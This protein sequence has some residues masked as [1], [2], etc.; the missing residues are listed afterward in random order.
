MR[1]LNA[2]ERSLDSGGSGGCRHRDGGGAF[3][4]NTMEEEDRFFR[5]RRYW[6]QIWNGGDPW[7][8]SRA[9]ELIVLHNLKYFS[10]KEKLNFII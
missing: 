2:T 10:I 5:K 9:W 4:I 3:T 7:L 1:L 8:R 6:R